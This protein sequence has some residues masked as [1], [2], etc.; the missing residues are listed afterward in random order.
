MFTNLNLI[1]VAAY[2]TEQ[3][4]L[5]IY[6]NVEE[7]KTNGV[8]VCSNTSTQDVRKSKF[9]IDNIDFNENIRKKI[10]Y[11]DLR[12]KSKTNTGVYINNFEKIIG[13]NSKNEDDGF[14]QEYEVC[15]YAKVN[16][17]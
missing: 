15:F 13:E 6:Q 2:N 17:Y 4:D 1:F 3:V 8:Q 16:N 12:W 9:D 14:K 11:G 5:C 7:K 10:M